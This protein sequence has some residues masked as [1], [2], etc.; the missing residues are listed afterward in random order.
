MP[1]QHKQGL[2]D[3]ALEAVRKA[4][5]S[6]VLPQLNSK[7]FSTGST[8]AYAD[9]RFPLGDEIVKVTIQAIVV[10]SKNGG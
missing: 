9:V 4:I 3:K 5:T 2:D 10:G 8:G 7:D 1:T 6:R